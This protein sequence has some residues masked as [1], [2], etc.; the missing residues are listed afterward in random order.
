MAEGDAKP[1]VHVPRRGG[2]G[3][4]ARQDCESIR[5]LLGFCFLEEAKVTRMMH[6]YA[7]INISIFPNA[8]LHHHLSESRI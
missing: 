3:G 8:S 5:W 7:S 6:A 2:G 1:D 4:G